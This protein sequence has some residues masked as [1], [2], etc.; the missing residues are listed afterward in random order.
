[1]LTLL[2]LFF[3]SPSDLGHQCYH[4]RAAATARLS[5][6]LALPLVLAATPASGEAAWRLRRCFGAVWTQRA[7]DAWELVCF[8][9]DPSRFM[10]DPEGWLDRVDRHR[11][12]A[13]AETGA[14]RWVWD[15]ATVL[16]SNY[17]FVR[18]HAHAALL[19]RFP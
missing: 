8:R 11:L 7:E 19:R 5:H 13:H 12:F 14:R 10:R 9:A 17:W 6:P 1:M 2:A 3:P 16:P 4:V 15:Y 18:D